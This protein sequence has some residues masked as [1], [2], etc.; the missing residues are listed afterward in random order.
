M[1][2]YSTLNAASLTNYVFR[3]DTTY[4]ISG[5]LALYSTTVIEGGTCLKFPSNSAVQV[6]L[7]GPV[8]CRTSSAHPA[9]FTGKDDNTVGESISGSS[10]APGG[11]Y[12]AYALAT[13]DT[14]TV[15]DLHDLRFRYANYAIACWLNS[16][17]VIR[18]CQFSKNLKAVAWQSGVLLTNRNVLVTDQT[19][20]FYSAGTCTPRV[21]HMTAHRVGSFMTSTSNIPCVTNTL[22][23]SVTNNLVYSGGSDVVTSLDDT[24]FFAPTAGAGSHYLANGSG[25]RDVGTTNASSTILSD[26]KKRTTYTPILITNNVTA[27]TTWYPTAGRDTDVPDLGYHYDPIDY[28]V[29]GI[30]ITNATLLITNGTVIGIDANATNYGIRLDSGASLISEGSPIDLN[31]FVRTHC[32]QEG[33]SG[34][35]NNLSAIFADTYPAPANATLLRCRFTDFPLLNNSYFINQENGRG[36]FATFGLQDCQIKS[37]IL[38]ASFI[39]TNTVTTLTNCLLDRV[40]THFLDYVPTTFNV[41]NATF[42]EGSI[43]LSM[44]LL[45]A[46]TWQ[47]NLFDTTN[48][49]QYIAGT[50]IHDHNAYLTNSTLLAGSTSNNKVL[51]LTNVVYETGTLGRFYLSNSVPYDLLVDTGSQ[52]AANLG[53]YHYTQWASQ[54]STKEANSTVNPGF[55]YIAVDANGQPIDTDGD[56]YW[57]HSEDRNGNGTFDTGET[58]WQSYTSPNGLTGSPGLEVFTPLK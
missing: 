20:V 29:S 46:W 55:H 17:A 32:I 39:Q 4:Y 38:Y 52:S 28:L 43:D 42:R 50:L 1:L 27:N 14:T 22:L 18:H 26:L 40:Q 36:T 10:G 2:D 56:G 16:K 9:I 8:D 37:G 7:W 21:E 58:D 23:I 6:H 33:L 30:V 35:S 45:S 12:A 48:I 44:N 24:G 3:G 31:R 47:N 5:N 51:P 13:H 57:D 41:D 54:P 34:S 49:S 25:Y 19:Y 53:L 15:Y 11:F